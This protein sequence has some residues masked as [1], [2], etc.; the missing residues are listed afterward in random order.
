MPGV[1]V[2]DDVV[3]GTGSL[4]TRD[5]P[6]ESIIL[7]SPARIVGKVDMN[8]RKSNDYFDCKNG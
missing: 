4:V 7:G 3:I 1:T 6:N 2:G 8:K 5:V